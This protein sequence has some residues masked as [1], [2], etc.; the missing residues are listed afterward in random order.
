MNLAQLKEYIKWGDLEQITIFGAGDKWEIWGIGA[1]RIDGQQ[2]MKENG[3]PRTFRTLQ[4]A[5]AVLRS[6]GWRTS[7][8]IDA[9]AAPAS[10][11]G[12]SEDA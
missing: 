9:Y 5:Y 12:A 7:N 2:L 10:E 3:G 8:T 6:Y 11:E 4:G 1:A